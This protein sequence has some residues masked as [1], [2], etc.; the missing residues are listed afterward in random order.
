MWGKTWCATSEQVR[1]GFNG[2][3]NAFTTP[4]VADGRVL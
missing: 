3:C 4:V 1:L 2:P